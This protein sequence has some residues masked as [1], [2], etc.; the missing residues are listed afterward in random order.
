[1]LYFFKTSLYIHY[2]LKPNEMD[3]F[4]KM[5][6]FMSKIGVKILN[7]IILIGNFSKKYIK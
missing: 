5:E 7:I 2:D 6:Q 4:I 3:Y 1:M